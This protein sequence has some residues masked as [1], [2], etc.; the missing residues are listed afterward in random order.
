MSEVSTRPKTALVKGKESLFKIRRYK[1]FEIIDGV[2]T[3]KV[4]VN[5]HILSGKVCHDA[6]LYSRIN[7]KLG[8]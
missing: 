7:F 2:T 6:L 4:T 5:Q 8:R 3:L 1:I